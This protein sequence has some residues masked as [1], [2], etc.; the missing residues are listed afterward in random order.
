MGNV[1]TIKVPDNYPL[2][3]SFIAK[4]NHGEDHVG[5]CGDDQE[6]ILHTLLHDF[7]DLPL[8]QSLVAA[9]EGDELVGVLG[10]DIDRESK[11]TE[12]WGPFVV[13]EDCEKIATLMYNDIMNQ[14]PISLTQVL[15]FYNKENKNSQLFMEKIG[16][17]RKDEHTILTC[18]KKGQIDEAG[19][20]EVTPEY[21][22][23]FRELHD[24]SF[25]N[26][27][28]TSEE[29]LS[30]IDDHH[31]VFVAH[32]QNEL[33]GYVYCEANPQFSGGDIHFIAVTPSSRGLGIGKKLVNK[34]LTFLF[35]FEEIEEITLC[36]NSSNQAAIHVY[37]KVGFTKV[38]ELVFYQGK[39]GE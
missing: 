8:E 12:L 14:I 39:L 33:L 24:G 35:S 13:H 18:H 37:E 23:S 11:V 5:Y 26:A 10:M 30:K 6:E 28:E 17:I 20:V 36:V 19:I 9:Y 31:K 27:Y 2:I 21:Y 22:E 32:D 7:S 15:G 3:A 29:I 1:I 4:V 34:A 16:A 25:P 38:H